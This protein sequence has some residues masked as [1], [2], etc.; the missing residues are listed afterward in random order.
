M[1]RFIYELIKW[2]FC[3]TPA[4]VFVYAVNTELAGDI[5]IPANALWKILLSGFLTACTTVLL[6]PREG[7]KKP[8]LL[9]RGL[10]HYAA[11]NTVM[12]GCGCLFGWMR[13][14]ASGILMMLLSVAF[15]YLIAFFVYYLINVAQAHEINQKLKEKF[16]D[17]ES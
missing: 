9:A 15:V 6:A 4:I 7:N 2:F 8:V 13:L 17:K 14:N 1:R 5:S 16:N 11:L 10:I 3:I 12:I